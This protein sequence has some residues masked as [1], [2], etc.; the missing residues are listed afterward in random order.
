MRLA[1]AARA[2]ARVARI[3]ALAA[4]T[5]VRAGRLDGD[6]PAA[7]GRRTA[8][9]ATSSRR[10]LAVHGVE[11]R[12]DGAA[13]PDGPALVVSNHLSYLDPLVVA[14]A[15]PCVPVS[16]AELAA[17]PVFGAV[18]RGTG[19]LFVTRDSTTSRKRVMESA[20]AALAAGARVLNFPEG[21]TSDGAGVLPFRRGLFAV[22]QRLGV[23][24]L[25]LA[26]AY[27][28]PGLA[29]IGDATFVPHYLRF[30]ALARP[31]ATIT[32]GAPLPSRAY[33][34]PQA[35]A[36]A[37]RARVAGLLTE[38]QEWLRKTR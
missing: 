9:F 6:D 37:A 5:L 1:G 19:V 15:V 13:P 20:E 35:L 11:L 14:T 8:L 4:E 25:P 26:L 10:A 16:K 34:D 29:W 24:V 18:A 32:L 17:W 23:P 27:D 22:A 7:L 2:A 31:A 38:K 36:D 28:P 33:P 12:V 3:G 21:T 30:A